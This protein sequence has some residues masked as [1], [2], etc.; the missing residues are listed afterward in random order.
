MRMTE[1]KIRNKGF[2]KLLDELR[3]AAEEWIDKPEKREALDR[4]LKKHLEKQ[5]P[6]QREEANKGRHDGPG[7]A[8]SGFD[9]HKKYAV[10]SFYVI[11]KAPTICINELIKD[12]CIKI[13]I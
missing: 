11:N 12:L 13:F 5:N 9:I 6:Y 3:I 4:M 7:E 2:I 8:F 10:H 1:I